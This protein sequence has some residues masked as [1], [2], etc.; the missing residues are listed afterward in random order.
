[1]QAALTNVTDG[2]I[3][4][5]TGTYYPIQAATPTVTDREVSFNLATCVAIYGGFVGDET[6]RDAR[7]W[8]TN[9][10]T[11]S[12]DIG[13]LNDDTDNSYHVVY[14]DGSTTAIDNTAILDGFVISGGILM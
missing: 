9:V 4:V 5:A 12:G 10:T 14:G 1:M 11:L 7:D 8:D 6:T 3:W 13:T 2:E